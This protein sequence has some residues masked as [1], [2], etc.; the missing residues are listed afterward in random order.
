MRQQSE[1]RK[2]FIIGIDG[3]TF[4]IITPLIER[5]NLSTI[6]KLMDSGSFG[7]LTSTIL[8]LT[9]PAWASFMTGVN[10]GAHSIYDFMKKKENSY[11]RI[12]V[13][14]THIRQNTIWRIL[15]DRG[16][17]VIVLNVPMTYPPEKVNGIMISGFLAPEEDFCYPQGIIDEIKE[18]VGDY[19][20]HTHLTYRKGNETQFMNDLL[21]IADMR[22]DA[23][24]YLM[25]KYEWDVFMVHFSTCDTMCHWFWK[26]MDTTHPDHLQGVCRNAIF[27]IYE[28]IDAAIQDFLTHIDGNTVVLMVSDHGSGPVHKSLYI[29][30]W[31]INHRYIALKK[32]AKTRF[33]YFLHKRGL[34]LQNVYV[35][36]SAVGLSKVG[37]NVSEDT[38]T[39]LSTFFLSFGDIDWKRTKAFSAGN[40]GQLFLNVQ[41]REPEGSIPP[42]EYENTR[43]QLIEEV[44]RMKDSDNSAIVEHVYK[45]EEIY[46]GP[47]V[48]DAPDILF[49]TR[50]FL[51]EPARY[52][53][54]GSH[55]LVGPPIRMKSG[56]HRM[57]GIFVAAHPGCIKKSVIE[58]AEIIDVFSTIL[59]MLDEEI[60]E[61]VEGKVLEDIFE[62]DFLRNHPVR[63]AKVTEKKKEEMVYSEEEEEKVK[64]RLRNLGYFD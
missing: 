53:E 44:T 12:T 3:G 6:K 59:Y 47:Y 24:L 35:L 2:I 34:T 1:N 21:R 5:G 51:Y 61:Y 8:P 38:R 9:A 22:R 15:S 17:R 39:K 27:K 40:F 49:L 37:K 30:N 41:G 14:A 55:A 57:N 7:N 46:K 60:P 25:G 42:S 43:D 62:A 10:P 23:A 31:L 48:K 45:R 54:F 32:D 52:F 29:N 50:D 64:E 56:T 18:N 13:N 33:K 19:T 20:I 28:K 36:A 11:E 63:Y 4:D 26:D 58:G 16:K